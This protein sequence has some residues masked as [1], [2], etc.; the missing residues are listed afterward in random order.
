MPILAGIF[1]IL[2]IWFIIWFGEKIGELIGAIISII[3]S[4]ILRRK[5]AK[6][7]KR[8]ERIMQEEINQEEVRRE[9]SG[10]KVKPSRNKAGKNNKEKHS[11]KSQGGVILSVVCVIAAIY[12]LLIGNWLGVTVAMVIAILSKLVLFK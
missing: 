8:Q 7:E 3:L 10:K 1:I 12:F 9:E 6:L 11:P 2:A 4:I 5:Q